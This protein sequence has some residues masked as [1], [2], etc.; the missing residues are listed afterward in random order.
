KLINSGL[1]KI[2]AVSFVNPKVVPQM[3]DAEAVMEAVPDIAGV[4]YA[5]LVLSR[6]GLERAVKTKVHSIHLVTTLSDAFN[7]KNVRRTV[8]QS[9]KE[10]TEVMQDGLSAKK[11]VIAIL[12]TAFGCPFSGDV[13]VERILTVSEAFM[14]AGATGIT[15]ADTTGL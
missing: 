8:D 11:E 15:L 4:T 12:G 3:A 5:G 1:K 9:V 6:S 14:Q 7:L 10:L 2:E 13:P